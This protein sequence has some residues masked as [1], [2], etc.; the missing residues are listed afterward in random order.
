MIRHKAP[1][2][3][4]VPE[5]K[6]GRAFDHVAVPYPDSAFDLNGKPD[7][8]RARMPTWHG[9]YGPLF[10]FREHLLTRLPKA[11]VPSRR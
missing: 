8:I 7:W 1:H 5:P 10:G 3:F 2:S 6:H 9:I 4:Y 11:C